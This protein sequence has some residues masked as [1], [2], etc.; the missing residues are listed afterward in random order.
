MF[1]VLGVLHFRLQLLI[2]GRPLTCMSMHARLGRLVRSEKQKRRLDVLYHIM[3]GHMHK[4]R[5]QPKRALM[6]TTNTKWIGGSQ[7][8][9]CSFQSV[10][11]NS[12]Y[13]EYKFVL[14]YYN[15]HFNYTN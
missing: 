12:Y 6:F 10:S 14:F 9:F 11:C 7:V 5:Q 4:T 15:Y 2:V 13:I 8:E 3:Y 1:V